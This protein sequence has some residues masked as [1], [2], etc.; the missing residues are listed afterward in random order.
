[1]VSKKEFA[2]VYGAMLGDG[3]LSRVGKYHYFVELCGNLKEDF[4][5]LNNM[6]CILSKL[7]GKSIRIKKRLDQNKAELSCSSK[8]LFSIFESYD[9]PVGKK[10]PDLKIT[11]KLDSFLYKEIIQ[12]YFAT[13][14]CLVLANNNGIMYPR[15]EFSSISQ[16][17]LKQVLSFLLNIGM[18]GKLY[19]SHKY[20]NQW[21]DLY[22]I[23][24]NGMNNLN[25]FVDCIGFVNPKHIQKL[26]KYRKWRCR[27]FH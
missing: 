9:F 2:L 20:K 4:Q 25:I 18:K 8:K 3:C 12:G 22:R 13:D 11:N 6:N 15:I 16:S 14:G 7:R 5:F 19:V 26:K 17:L 24:F 1:M 10:G 21:H 23:Q 27:D